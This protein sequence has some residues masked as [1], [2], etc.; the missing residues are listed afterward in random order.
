MYGI[1][2]FRV[3]CHAMSVTRCTSLVWANQ[4]PRFSS[5]RVNPK[6]RGR[7]NLHANNVYP[8]S[9]A[10]VGHNLKS[11]T[12]YDWVEYSWI[13][14]KLVLCTQKVEVQS[15]VLSIR[16]LSYS[17]SAAKTSHAESASLSPPKIKVLLALI[18]HNIQGVRLRSRRARGREKCDKRLRGDR[19]SS[20]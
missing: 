9:R 20:A 18:G 15:T 10:T 13:F 2:R 3:S 4:N 6:L 1:L 8:L 17:T 16:S 5:D 11:F 12:Y 14:D 19:L 7:L